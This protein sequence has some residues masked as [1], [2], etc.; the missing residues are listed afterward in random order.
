MKLITI[1]FLLT[2][3]ASN[4][5]YN[6]NK[7]KEKY[8]ERCMD[9]CCKNPAQRIDVGDGEKVVFRCFCTPKD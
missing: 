9:I 5:V 6:I 1:I 3:C 7:L 8:I 4:D 2:G